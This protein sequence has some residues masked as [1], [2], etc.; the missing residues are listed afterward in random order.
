VN[1]IHLSSVCPK[2]SHQCV[3]DGDG[4][5]LWMYLHD[6]EQ[7]RVISDAPVC[8]LVEPISYDEFKRSYRRGDTPPFVKGY[9]TDR[10]V[11]PDIDVSRLAIQ[12]LDDGVSVMVSVDGDPF[13]IIAQNKGYS[14]AI[15]QSG[16]WGN[17]WDDQI[18]ISFRIRPRE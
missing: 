11:I 3:V 2:G 17:P 15:S 9:V 1:D 14:K 12:W 13:T 5:S 10:A 16:P 8:T 18:A 4:Q 7:N 6:L